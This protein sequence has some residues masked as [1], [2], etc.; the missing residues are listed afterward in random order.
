[1][2]VPSI[3]SLW[4]ETNDPNGPFGA[5][6]FSEAATIPSGPAVAN[7]IYNAI[8]I[9]FNRLPMTPEQILQAIKHYCSMKGSV[10]P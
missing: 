5:K 3:D 1:L 9:R 8:G 6:G 10:H 4:V 7:A 2:D